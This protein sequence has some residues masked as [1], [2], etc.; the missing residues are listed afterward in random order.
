MRVLL[1]EGDDVL[2]SVL[3]RDLEQA[4]FAVD[5]AA[6]AQR[7]AFLGVGGS[8]DVAILDLNLPGLSGLEVLRQW[9][10]SGQS[11]P[12]LVLTA[13]EQRHERVQALQAGADDHLGKPF[14]RDELLARLGALLRRRRAERGTR[15]ARQRFAPDDARQTASVEEGGR[16]HELA[17]GLDE[18]TA[19]GLLHDV[20]RVLGFEG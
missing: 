2:R 13:R 10:A 8:C 9:R 12:V 6:D 19:S 4:G 1:V 11:M 3:T 17:T 20:S 18:T 5:A 15:L 16:S 7:G 14:D